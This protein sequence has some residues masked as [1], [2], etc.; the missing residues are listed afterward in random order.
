MMQ[1]KSQWSRM[2][3]FNSSG[4]SL[5]DFPHWMLLA[6]SLCRLPTLSEFPKLKIYYITSIFG[7]H[8][9]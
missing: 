5:D 7:S 8:D 3:N 1:R 2:G 4:F 6:L 9:D